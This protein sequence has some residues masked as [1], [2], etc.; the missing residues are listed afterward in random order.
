MDKETALF[1]RSALKEV[2]TRPSRPGEG[3]LRARER[4]IL[5]AELLSRLAL[6]N[7]K[8]GDEFQAGVAAIVEYLADL[9][10]DQPSRRDLENLMG[11]FSEL[12]NGK[13]IKGIQF[14]DPDRPRAKPTPIAVREELKGE[15]RLRDLACELI[16]PVNN[17]FQCEVPPDDPGSNGGD[18]G[19]GA[20]ADAE[21]RPRTSAR[22]R[23]KSSPRR[24]TSGRGAFARTRRKQTERAN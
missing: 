22:R 24:G 14:T 11:S 18:D 20:S 3:P 4:E 17:E 6:L 2:A 15:G 13:K 7:P 19:G 12:L 23:S 16:A 9:A 1:V 5:G 21:S 10:F 8:A